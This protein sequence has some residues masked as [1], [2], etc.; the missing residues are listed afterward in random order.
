[1][2]T[3]SVVSAVNCARG[4]LHFRRAAIIFDSEPDFLSLIFGYPG[5]NP[6]LPRHLLI[7]SC[8][9]PNTYGAKNNTCLEDRQP[10][11]YITFN[12]L[13]IVYS[14][15]GKISAAVFRAD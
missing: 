3:D 2:K 11:N 4:P 7:L 15:S 9:V 10:K 12:K 8:K 1:M 14:L 5:F 13:R 6:G